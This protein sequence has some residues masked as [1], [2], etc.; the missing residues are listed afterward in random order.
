[1]SSSNIK[2]S[3]FLQTRTN[4][5]VSSV[6][7]RVAI[8][9]GI[10]RSATEGTLH[11]S[12][13]V[14]KNSVQR[15]SAVVERQ[16]A[17]CRPTG[18]VRTRTDFE[19]YLNR[20]YRGHQ[21]RR[22][23]KKENE[24]AVVI[25]RRYRRHIS[26]SEKPAEKTEEDKKKALEERR[27]KRKDRDR[28]WKDKKKV[29]VKKVAEVQ[30]S[31]QVQHELHCFQDEIVELKWNADQQ[32]EKNFMLDTEPARIVFISSKIGK[33]ELLADA[34][35]D[36]PNVITI[37]YDFEKDTFEDLI[38]R[39]RSKLN[40]YKKGC[41]AQSVCLYCQGGP[42]FLYVVKRKVLTAVKLKKPSEKDQRQFWTS[43][44]D[45]M[46]KVNPDN[47]I[48]HVM[49]SNILG[50]EN[51]QQLF[52]DISTLMKPNKVT[53]KSPLELSEEAKAMIDI[54]FNHEK[55]KDWKLQRYTKVDNS[56][57]NTFKENTD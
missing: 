45:M 22:Q 7:N 9:V 2:M 29:E 42:G 56:L 14:P 50:S 34:V 46:S 52:D 4:S 20:V 27:G 12:T 30:I 37:A 19:F 16:S 28:A 15:P 41:R 43:V 25:Q 17:M 23:M 57:I 53:F 13:M 49:G 40:E 11:R 54:Y 44:G 48:V 55:Y 1:M 3:S 32:L 26:T 5:S 31:D 39:M 33:P 10:Q 24:M 18:M 38:D 21:E 51:G 35:L 8:P 36:K 47:T 6:R